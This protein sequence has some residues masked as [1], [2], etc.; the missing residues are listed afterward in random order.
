[1]VKSN[2]L[3]GTVTLTNTL[4][5]LQDTSL[6]A[7][8]SYVI[9]DGAGAVRHF[10]VTNNATLRLTNLTL[11]NGCFRAAEGEPNQRG[12]PA[13][14]GSIL[15]SG[16]RLEL[17]SCC[18]ISNQ[19]IG[20]NAGP[21]AY[22]PGQ[23]FYNDAGSAFG[24]AIYSTNGSVVV[25]NCRFWRNRCSGG[26]G[27]VDQLNSSTRGGDAF[28]GALCCTNSSLALTGSTFTAN[29]VVGG[30][31]ATSY[32]HLSQ[33]GGIACGGALADGGASTIASNCTLVANQAF[34]G[35]I[36]SK[37]ANQHQ[38]SARGGAIFHGGGAL[39]VEATLLA[40]NT[41]LGG[42]GASLY[43]GYPWFYADG[44]G[45]AVFNTGGSQFR[46]S[47]FIGN[48]AKGGT[49]NLGCCFMFAY[50]G[51]GSG[52]G[53]CNKGELA[54]INCTLAENGAI[55][56][57]ASSWSFGTGTGGSAYGGAIF[58]GD[59]GTG[60][61]LLNV[62][63]ASNYVRAGTE[64]DH[65]YP[66]VALAASI[67]ITTNAVALTNTIF[68]CSTSQT[69]V[70]GTILDGGHN[71]CSDGSA[72]FTSPTSRGSLDP[73]LGPVGYYG[74]STPTV[75]LLPASPAIDAGDDSANPPTDQRGVRRLQGFASD[76]GAFELAPTL[77]LASVEGGKTRVNCL[78]QANRTNLF[79]AS[80][81]LL[82]WTPL[83]SRISDTN[84]VSQIEEVDISEKV[85][86]F[87]QMQSLPSR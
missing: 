27:G 61:S 17:V 62:T 78:F 79:N 77:Q 86:R 63:L 26:Q 15:N 73:L 49:E 40:N 53:I 11:T 47:A 3:N 82:E 58:T 33:G 34:G 60:A 46:N 28:G 55:G 13:F 59:S 30:A 54:L 38:S 85:H 65:S 32:G 57:D 69:N 83:G 10:V 81:D 41:A 4:L 43:A 16:G 50:G 35:A 6:D 42:P 56:G 51:N 5:I 2:W 45:G 84:G 87:Y 66:P 48:Q 21:P 23:R 8:G 80:T 18:F 71:I 12:N 20:G 52:G 67:F 29:V 31:V 74:G 36:V 70:S 9:L 37:S 1:V 76:I 14:G 75:P 44:E 19:A 72:Q 68:V 64:S 22:V 25:S 39:S 7:S 24:G